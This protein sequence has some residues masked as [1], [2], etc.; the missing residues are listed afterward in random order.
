MAEQLKKLRHAQGDLFVIDAL[1]A[2]V[3]DDLASM[4]HPFYSLSKKPVK[5][6]EPYEHNGTTIEFRPSDRGFPTIYDKDL[7]IYAV[8]HAVAEMEDGQ[9]APLE[10]EFDPYDFLVFT[11]RG[12][13]GRDYL[14]IADSIDRLMGSFFRTNAKINGQAEY[15]WRGIID[16]ADMTV[17]EKTK[18]PKKL[19][20]KLSEMVRETIEKRA[21]LTLNRDYFRLRKPIER[22]IYQLARKHSGH[23]KKPFTPYLK[24]LHKKSGS[25][26]SLREFRRSIRNI[27]D[28]NHLPDFD[29]HYDAEKDQVT[30]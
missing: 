9:K 1:D 6:I 28:H 10:V 11:Q 14:S 19:R 4:E 17:D 18:R 2:I 29:T 24:T 23:Q 25:R 30:L 26:S 21:V 5:D 27:A 20:I 16:G 8:S 15:K 22:R 13:G 12:T 3:K 7:I